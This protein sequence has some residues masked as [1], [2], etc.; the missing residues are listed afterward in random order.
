MAYKEDLD[1]RDDPQP[2]D[3][4]ELDRELG[5]ERCTSCGRAVYEGTPKCPYCGQWLLED[6]DAA[7]RSR[8]WLWPI[9]VAL[10]LA[11]ILVLWHG[12]G[13]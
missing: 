6:S 13:I 12:L 1:D 7:R 4:E 9:M 2:E 5:F 8:G 10:L 3:I 11:V